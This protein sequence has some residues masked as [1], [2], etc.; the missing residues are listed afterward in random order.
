[1][2]IYSVYWLHKPE[3][4]DIHSQGY[5][6]VSNDPKRRLNEHKL[7]SKSDKNPYLARVLNKHQIIQSIIFQETEE[8]CYAREEMLRPEK[9]IGWNI[10]RGGFRPPS[11]KG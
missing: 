5:V 8:E 7:D 1:M 3:Y 9:N 4:T 10:T 6:G 2:N 11:R